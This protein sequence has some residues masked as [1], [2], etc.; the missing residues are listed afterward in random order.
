LSNIQASF[1]TNKGQIRVTLFADQAPVTVANFVNLCRR[2]F[3]DGLKFHRVIANFMIQGGCP[4][5]TGTGD[6]GYKFEDE[7]VAELRHAKPGRLSMANSGPG[8]N[9]SQFFITHGPTPHLDDAHTIFG[10]VVGDEDQDVVNSIAQGDT[11][12]GISLEGD[13]DALLE[14][15]SDRI[16]GWNKQLGS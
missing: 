8:T 13:V 11:I 5:G 7:F 6:P 2:G 10:E 3:Y 12:N 9:G 4:Q 14:Q 1:D 15:L 16:E